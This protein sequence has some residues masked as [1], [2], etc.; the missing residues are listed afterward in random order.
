MSFIHKPLFTMTIKT[1][2]HNDTQIKS[3]KETKP[4]N[5]KSK[6]DEN[7]GKEQGF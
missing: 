5:V 3:K 4:R 6:P 7:R 1:Q 2:K